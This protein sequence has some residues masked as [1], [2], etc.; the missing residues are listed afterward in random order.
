MHCGNNTINVL[1]RLLNVPEHMR[2]IQ[3]TVFFQRTLI[4][5][6]SVLIAN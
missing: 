6:K 1:V 4:L 2:F 3:D 5:Q